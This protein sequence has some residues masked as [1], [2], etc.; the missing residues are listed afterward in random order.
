MVIELNN[1]EL[2]QIS[3]Q[4]LI[5]KYPT[6]EYRHHLNGVSGQEPYK[7]YAYISTLFDNVKLA[8]IG[9]RTGNSALAFSHNESNQVDS[10]D[11]K[12]CKHNIKRNNISFYLENILIHPKILNYDIICLDIDPH[13]GTKEQE[14]LAFLMGNNWRGLLVLDDIG[15][16]WPL[17]HQW[18]HKIG[19]R[20]WDVTKYGHASGTGIVDFANKLAMVEN[21]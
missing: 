6:G 19:L 14:C 10:Y 5:D 4:Y 18:W 16:D 13:D 21:D 3:L 1:T 17:M 9:T 12:R 20:K 7:L 2:D 11:I 8:D 15:T